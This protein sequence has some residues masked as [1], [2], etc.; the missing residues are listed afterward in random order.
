[1]VWGWMGSWG[2][3]SAGVGWGVGGWDGG[4]GKADG[5]GVRWGLWWLGNWCWDWWWRGAAV[6]G[7]G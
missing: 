6:L 1:M 7:W 3:G 2:V 5:L 4:V